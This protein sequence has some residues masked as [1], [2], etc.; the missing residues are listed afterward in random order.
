[1]LAAPAARGQ[2]AAQK[3]VVISEAALKTMSAHKPKK[4]M[5]LTARMAVKR[6][7]TIKTSTADSAHFQPATVREITRTSRN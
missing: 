7:S 6:Q 5:P 1:M 4:K 2:G 3:T